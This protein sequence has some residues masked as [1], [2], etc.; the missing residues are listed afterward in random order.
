MCFTCRSSLPT[1]DHTLGELSPSN[2][3]M[4][5]EWC[6]VQ[7]DAMFYSKIVYVIPLNTKKTPKTY[8]ENNSEKLA[9]VRLEHPEVKLGKCAFRG[10][11]VRMSSSHV[12]RGAIVVGCVN[13]ETKEWLEEQV[14]ELNPFERVQLKMGSAK[15]LVKIFKVSTFIPKYIKVDS[16]QELR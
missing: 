6:R 9:I 13:T 15:S 12:G 7:P 5:L 10:K 11:N 2:R 14:Q 16:K 3:T 8:A 1:S 4:V